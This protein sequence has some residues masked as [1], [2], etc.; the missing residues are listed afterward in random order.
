MAIET[1]GGL[2]R[3]A[4]VHQISAAFAVSGP[5]FK[6]RGPNAEA[7]AALPMWVVADAREQKTTF[8]PFAAPGQKGIYRPDRTAIESYSGA[9]VEGLDNPRDSLKKIALE[10]AWSAPQVL[11]FLIPGK[12]IPPVNAP[13]PRA[14]SRRTRLS[15]EAPGVKLTPQTWAIIG[16]RSSRRPARKSKTHIRSSDVRKGRQARVGDRCLGVDRSF[17]RLLHGSGARQKVAGFCPVPKARPN[18][19]SGKYRQPRGRYQS[20]C[21]AAARGYRP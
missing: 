6:Q 11:Y 12:T 19:K 2:E 10:T 3:W 16:C 14:S 15:C 7:V 4:R 8:E 1:H 18:A 13:Y 20:S 9:L 17:E 5:G 21:H